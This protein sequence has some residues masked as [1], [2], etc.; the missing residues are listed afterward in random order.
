MDNDMNACSYKE[1]PLPACAPLAAPFV[2]AQ[3]S[4][5]PR[6]EA[7]KALARGTLFPGLDLPFKNMVNKNSPNVPL[8]ELMALDFVTYE[9]GLYLDTHCNDREAFEAYQSAMKLSAE[10]RKRYVALYGPITKADM[11][12]AKSFTW[13]CDPWPWEYIAD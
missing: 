2:P 1:G 10:G 8:S 3:Q 6:Y 11:A 9:L 12:E 13:L 5:Q 4:S 7:E